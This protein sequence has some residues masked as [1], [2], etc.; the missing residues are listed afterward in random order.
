MPIHSALRAAFMERVERLRQQHGQDAPLFPDLRVYDGRRN[1]DASNK[2]NAWLD[3]LVA[4]GA[5]VI[6]DADHK[7]YHSLRHT[8]STMLKGRTWADFITGHA[9]R[10][11]KSKVYEHPPL[12]EVVEDVE[13]LAWPT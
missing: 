1:K 10:T 7:S 12:H 2:A 9:A 5:V 8:V 3:A 13:S 4:A 11:V 6:A